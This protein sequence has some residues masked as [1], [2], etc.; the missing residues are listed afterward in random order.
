[1]P[2]VRN[3]LEMLAPGI[4]SKIELGGNTRKEG[5]PQEED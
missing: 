1:M 4:S 5:V 3:L 2:E